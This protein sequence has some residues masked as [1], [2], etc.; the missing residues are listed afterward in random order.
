MAKTL[1]E[2]DIT[3]TIQDKLYP[4]HKSLS[5]TFKP[6]AQSMIQELPEQI[7]AV[8]HIHPSD[9]V[10]E[11]GGS[12]GRNSCVI[13]TIL[14]DKSRHVV[15]EPSKRELS[16]LLYNRDIHHFG[17][18]VVNS[19]ISHVPL[20]A[21][22]WHT[23]HTQVP[24]SVEVHTSTYQEFQSK[25]DISFNV[26]VIDNEGNFVDTLKHFPSILD[27]IRLLIIEHDFNSVDD[28]NY[29][30]NTMESSGFTLKTKYLK[31]S[32][33]APGIKWSDGQPTDPIFVSAWERV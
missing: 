19:A 27:T 30:T 32:P 16:T 25:V 7:M 18:T 1:T 4:I 29:F 10:L 20:F 8:M 6:N 22:N 26:L 23:Y 5:S 3:S 9:S 15:V 13:N 31:T 11:L 14:D 2:K 21:R 24:G 28:V 12:I 17:F 33:Y